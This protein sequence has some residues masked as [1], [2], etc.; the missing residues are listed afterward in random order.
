MLD[1]IQ[2]LEDRVSELLELLRNT[3]KERDDLRTRLTSLEAQLVE[4]E[5]ETE[6]SGPLAQLEKQRLQAL[7]VVESALAEL[8]H[9]QSAA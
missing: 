3:V 9:N 1:S 8:G 5:S 4:R 2:T 7:E 6:E